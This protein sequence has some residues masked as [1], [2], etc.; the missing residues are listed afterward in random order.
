VNQCCRIQCWFWIRAVEYSANSES[1]YSAKSKSALIASKEKL[2]VKNTPLKTDISVVGYSTNSESALYHTVLILN[3]RC[4]I[5][6]W[7]RISAVQYDTALI[8]EYSA[9]LI[10]KFKNGVKYLKILII[11]MSI[12]W[13]KGYLNRKNKNK[14]PYLSSNKIW[15][16]AVSY[17]ADTHTN[18]DISEN[19]KRNSKIF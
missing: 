2:L 16:R 15:I 6:R 11:K 8:H 14:N 7:F 12:I 3:Q 4:Q 18:P 17:S 13:V 1:A 5:H 10:F 19:S 9:K